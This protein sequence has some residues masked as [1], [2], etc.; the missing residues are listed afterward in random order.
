MRPPPLPALLRSLLRWPLLIVLTVLAALLSG[1]QASAGEPL[2]P[3]AVP[4]PLKP[5]IGWAL[6]GKEEARCPL[7]FGKAD[8]TRCDWPSRLEL[9]LDEHGGRFTQKWHLDAREWV[10]LPGDDRRW[11]TGVTVDGGRAIVLANEGA[12]RVELKP[13]DHEV[14]GT[15]RWDS[16]P[17]SVP[18]PTE[19]GLLRLTLRGQLVAWPN[20]DAKGTL[21]L[22]KAADSTTEEGDAIELVVHRKVTDDIPMRLETHIEIHVA[23]KNREELLGKALPPGFVPQSLEGPVPARLEPDGRLRV[24]VR[25][26]NFT[27]T[28]VARSDGPVKSLTR[29]DPDG[30]WRGGEEVWV[31]E[32]KPDYRVVT[33]E[34]VASIDPQQTTLP[35]GWKQL[36]AYPMKVG[37]TL[38][39]TERRRG[40]A[41]PPADQLT[42]DREL[43]LDF[44]GGGYTVND[45]ITGQ[46]YSGS[47]LTMDPPTVLGR[48]SVGQGDQFITH[49]PGDKPGVEVRQGNL[50][51]DADSRI[52]GDISDIPAASWAHKFRQVRGKLHLPPGWRLLHISGAGD[53]PQTWLRHWTLLELFL[54]L[55]VSIGVGRL[56]GTRWGVVS[57]ATLV[58]I[59][60]ETG[61]P[62]WSWLFVLGVDA[63]ARVIP[64]GRIKQL[65]V[66]ARAAAV[67]LVAIFALPFLVRQV[68]LGMYPVLSNPGAA[69]GTHERSSNDYEESVEQ[70]EEASADQKEGGTGT[71]AK[72]E[73]GS[74]GNPNTKDTGHRYGVRGPPDNNALTYDPTVMVQTGPGVPS[75]SWATFELTW[76]GPVGPHDRLHLYLASPAV[77]LVLAFVRALLVALLLLRLLP[78]TQRFFPRGWGPRMST[79]AAGAAALLSLLVATP[80]RADVP[81]KSV[82]DDLTGRLTRAPDCAPNCASI[83][84]MALDV[85]GGVLRARLEIDAVAPTGVPLPGTVGQWSPAEVLLDGAPA[86]GMARLDDGVLWIAVGAGAHQV[87]LEGPMPDKDSMQL[88]LPLKPHRVESDAVGWTVAGIHEDGLAD[89]DIELTRIRKEEKADAGVKASLQP[90]ELPPFVRVERT[91]HVALD[92]QVD[93]RVVRVTPPG[94]A[95]VLE[96]PLLPG[97]SVT[98]ADVRVAGGKALVNMGPKATDVSW[99]SVLEERSPIK[100][101]APRSI[102]WVEVWRVDVGPIWHSTI[103]GIVPVH[104]QPVGGN[105]PQVPEWRPWPGEELDIALMRPQGVPG[106]TL[107]IDYS[108]MTVKPGA[109]ATDVELAVGLRSSRGGEHSFLLPAGATLDSILVNNQVLPL[110]QDGRKVTVPL[111]PGATNV[112]LKLSD[113]EGIGPWF[114]TQP[115][116]LGAPSVNATATVEVPD[117]RWVL[118]AYGPRGGPA[119]LFWSLLL[120]LAAVSLVLGRSTLAPLAWWQWLLLSIGLSQVSVEWGAVFVGWLLVLGWRKRTPNESMGRGLFNLRQAGLV[121]WTF[122]ALIVLARSLYQGLLGSPEMQILGNNSNI[123]VLRWYVDRAD[124]TPPSAWMI[125]VPLLVYRAAMLAWALWIALAL[126]RWLKW[127]WAAFTTG[128]AWRRKPPPLDLAVPPPA[129]AP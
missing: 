62:K 99:H 35:G 100:L 117:R 85:H 75:W 84:R 9:V 40:D 12:P 60:P 90:G 24:Q 123:Y 42:L 111:A 15:F 91:L 34:G 4:E 128:G 20:R 31:F 71:R 48:V 32:A 1:A 77:N 2:D 114:A 52:E 13:G 61:A 5:W 37:A 104:T 115:V 29:T 8:T 10:P 94:S 57:L 46:L 43:W 89:D 103:T 26:G 41:N 127:G 30:P 113:P 95:V 88:S 83:G 93:T 68:R 96:V 125:S 58:L 116:D 102:S 69:L 121:I 63:L 16:L 70:A 108:K 97:E 76:S 44:H 7:I 21:W 45:V 33:V 105:A 27:L 55:I 28:L 49:M 39:F 47:R 126:L 53:V 120:V 51:I 106:Q 122:I 80:A 92:W 124:P 23:G 22:Q 18:I 50:S 79:G 66:G 81:D 65:F 59:L 36:P 78:W 101:V 87:T 38:T 54:A 64:A 109:G 67:L 74:M 129:A 119:V 118:F 11:P 98:T 73:E 17:E 112:T 82:L 25:P 56:Y 107:T 3:R 86:R 110:R 72:G 14:A 19:T 6:D